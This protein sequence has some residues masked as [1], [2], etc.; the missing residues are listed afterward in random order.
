MGIHLRNPDREKERNIFQA[1][2]AANLIPISVALMGLE[3]LDLSA[4]PR[5]EWA[6]TLEGLGSDAGIGWWVERH[7]G[8]TMLLT[9]W[10]VVN[11]STSCWLVVI[12][13]RAMDLESFVVGQDY[14]IITSNSL[15]DDVSR[16][17]DWLA[18]S[19]E[20]H[21][22]CHL[23]VAGRRKVCASPLHGDVLVGRLGNLFHWRW[24]LSSVCK[25]Q[26]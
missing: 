22:Q 9:C 11:K 12:L 5:S 6:R 4:K 21:E 8:S 19:K 2:T 24:D 20:G 26:G 7:T 18:P 23:P 10:L 3:R 17:H 1:S 16:A 14:Y 13:Y 25:W 15:I